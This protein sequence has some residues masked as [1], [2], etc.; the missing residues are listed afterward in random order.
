MR[1]LEKAINY[2]FK[3]QD[4]LLTALTHK[5]CKNKKNNERLEYLGDAVLDLLI[6]EFLYQEFPEHKEGD[7]SKMRAALVNEQSFMRFAKAIHLQ[8]FIL[9][10]SNEETNQGREKPSILSSAFEALIGAVYLEAGLERAK[11]ITYHL[12]HKLYPKIDTQSLFTDYKT[13][14]QELTQAHFHEI[15]KYELLEEIGP[16]HCKKFKVS[17]YIQNQE[18]AKAIGTSKKSAQ[19]NCAKIA[20]QKIME[21]KS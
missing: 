1:N 19:Q 7:L 16:D 11:D 9:I 20:Y 2:H 10:S 14:L 6:G 12:L 3:N 5:S 15:P 13:A 21:Q 8:D 4:L 17:V 18:Y